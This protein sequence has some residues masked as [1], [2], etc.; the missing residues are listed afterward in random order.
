MNFKDNESHDKLRG[1]YYTP[2]EIAK[3]LSRWVLSR[4]PKTLLE[5]SC[6]DGAF[7]R[8]LDGLHHHNL[9]LTA[10]ERQ[11]EE[12]MK[13]SAAAASLKRVKAE[14]VNEDFLVPVHT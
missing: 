9:A 7:I 8:A 6:G 12:A 4:K 5:P 11:P 1:G 2:T 3:F 10:V 14:I 13:S